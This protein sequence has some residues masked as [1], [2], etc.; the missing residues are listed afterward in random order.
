MLLKASRRRRQRLALGL[1]SRDDALGVHAQLDNFERHAAADG[2][3][4]LGHIDHAT[5]AFAD[6]L[7]QFVTANLIASLLGG[8][9]VDADGSL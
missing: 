8:R 7:K 4:L 1:E 9:N 2:F 6:L 5:A 3:L